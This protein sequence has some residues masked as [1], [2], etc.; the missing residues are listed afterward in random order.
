VLSLT[1]HGQVAFHKNRFPLQVD[2]Q[3]TNKLGA[4]YITNGLF[5]NS[6]PHIFFLAIAF[7]YADMAKDKTTTFQMSLLCTIFQHTHLTSLNQTCSQNMA[8]AEDRTGE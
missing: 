2:E 8:E 3:L 5:R 4:V 7:L 1:I 6:F